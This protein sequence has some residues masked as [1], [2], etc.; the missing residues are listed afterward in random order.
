MKKAVIV[1]MVILMGVNLFA[2]TEVSDFET[3]G[4]GTI[5]K[6]VGFDNTVVIPA[7]I[8]G[9]QITAI[10]KEAFYNCDLVDITIPVGIVSIGQSAFSRNK[11]TSIV[12]P[13]GVTYIENA[14][15]NANPLTD[16]NIPSSLIKQE[17]NFSRV[18]TMTLGE[19]I[20]CDE[21]D[22]H[23]NIFYDYVCND[24]K[25]GTYRFDPDW[26]LSSYTNSRQRLED[27]DYYATENGTAIIYYNGTASRFRI[28]DQLNGI[29]IKAIL[30]WNN[31]E[32][33]S[34]VVMPNSVSYIGKNA[35]SGH[36]L[37][38]ID[39]PDC[40]TYIGERAFVDN[41][42]TSVTIPECVTYIGSDAFSGAF[43][44][45]ERCSLI[46]PPDA[47]IGKHAF[48]GGIINE[49]VIP[50]TFREIGESAFYGTN[51]KSLIVENEQ[52][53]YGAFENA[54]I[55]TLVIKNNS[56]KIGKNAFRGA[57]ITKIIIA[58]N[59]DLLESGLESRFLRYYNNNGKKAGIYSFVQSPNGTLAWTYSEE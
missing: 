18:D 25:A 48:S 44:H 50:N 16:A 53:G 20:I 9:E 55:E 51:I 42:F 19:G 38:T 34:V 10:G 39:L 27:I 33:L 1:I 15:F 23:G 41:D 32:K 57:R 37:S 7:V 5:V 17:G 40:L 29:P 54:D 58:S 3:D 14:A 49:L 28:P 13:E 4:K 22:F 30:G 36:N 56:L 12:I 52:I 31:G 26:N 59:V 6:Y 46:L 45:N 47:Y 43:M 35:F 8:N 11:L 24:R 21:N 2:Q